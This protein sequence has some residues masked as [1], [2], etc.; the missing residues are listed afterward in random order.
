MKIIAKKFTNGATFRI[1]NCTK[2]E[3][4]KAQKAIERALK[5]ET[6]TVS[7]F[8]QPLPT[9]GPGEPC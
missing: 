9:C 4:E 7:T 8:D 6:A 2:K 1:E 3:A 5:C